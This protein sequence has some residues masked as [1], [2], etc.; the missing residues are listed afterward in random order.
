ME[1][2]SLS[3]ETYFTSANLVHKASQM[4]QPI[5]SFRRR[6]PARFAPSRSALLVLDMQT[7][8]LKPSSHAYIPSALAI[9]PG[10]KALTQSFYGYN[11]PVIFSRHLNTPEDAGQMAIWWRDLIAAESPLSEITPEL[12]TS[13]GDIVQ[14]CQYDAFQATSLEKTL[15]DRGVS[16]VVICGVM[17]HLCCE[18]TAR[19]A[20]MHGFEVFFTVDGTATYT[21]AFHR[22]TL[23][24]LAHGF[25]TLVLVRDILA[26]I[27]AGNES[28]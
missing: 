14:K 23:L 21:E 24:N 17:T 13:M 25:A 4:L 26:A 5:E 18:T 7:Y 9:L 3:K 16:Q 2:N 1:H 19:S 15:R 22:A 6:H 8:F 20:F 28:N 12:D 10:I 11:L 27:K